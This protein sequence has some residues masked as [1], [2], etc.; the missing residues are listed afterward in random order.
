LDGTVSEDSQPEKKPNAS[1]VKTFSRSRIPFKLNAGENEVSLSENAL[2]VSVFTTPD[3][4][5]I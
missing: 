4:E 1:N 3:P 5:E 2:D